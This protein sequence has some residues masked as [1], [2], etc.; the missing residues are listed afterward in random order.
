MRPAPVNGGAQAS[1]IARSHELVAVRNGLIQTQTQVSAMLAR[2]TRLVHAMNAP[3]P[4]TSWEHRKASNAP[5]GL[6]VGES[7]WGPRRRV[8]R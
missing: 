2:V 7:T 5:G 3:A 6:A 4:A 1:A 8:G